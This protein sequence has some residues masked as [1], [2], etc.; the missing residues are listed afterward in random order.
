MDIVLFCGR[1]LDTAAD[2]VGF[3]VLDKAY[4]HVDD[5]VATAG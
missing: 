4:V 3:L 5:A 1:F 2:F